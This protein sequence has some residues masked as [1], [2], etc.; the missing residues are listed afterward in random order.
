MGVEA[1]RRAP[2]RVEAF[3]VGLGEVTVT[4]L[5]SHERETSVSCPPTLLVSVS[6]AGSE[7]TAVVASSEGTAVVAS[8]MGVPVSQRI[9]VVPG[10]GEYRS[11][12]RR[13][14]T[15]TY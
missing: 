6:R 13:R 2:G 4:P 14:S 1:G 11:H 5:A 15:R 12:D 7:G 9:C 3:L 8:Q 10:L